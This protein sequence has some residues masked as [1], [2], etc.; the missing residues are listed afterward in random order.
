MTSKTDVSELNPKKE[1]YFRSIPIGECNPEY[2]DQFF[3][4]VERF[5][6]NLCENSKLKRYPLLFMFKNENNT[7]AVSICSELSKEQIEAWG[8]V[9]PEGI[10]DIQLPHSYDFATKLIKEFQPQAIV[11]VSAFVSDV[12][13]PTGGIYLHGS[14][15]DLSWKREKDLGAILDIAPETGKVGTW[16]IDNS[17]IPPLEDDFKGVKSVCNDILYNSGEKTFG[18]R[19]SNEV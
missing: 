11:L 16:N 9:V 5:V 10:D 8:G 14:S 6:T 7:H 13:G 18:K 17:V 2:L 15:F 12:D 4:S 1:A 19:D 3:D